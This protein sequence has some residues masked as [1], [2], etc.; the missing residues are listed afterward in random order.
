MPTNEEIRNMLT[1]AINIEKGQP[2]TRWDIKQ[3]V[4]IPSNADSA[5]INSIAAKF[6]DRLFDQTKGRSWTFEID[7][8][9]ED[10]KNKYVI[11]KVKW[12]SK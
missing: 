6:V 11:F 12:L 3:R 8:I 7:V 2:R 9:D 4:A 5:W 10:D 1:N